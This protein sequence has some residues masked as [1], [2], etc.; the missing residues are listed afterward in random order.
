MENESDAQYSKLEANSNEVQSSSLSTSQNGRRVIEATEVTVI[1]EAR[2]VSEAYAG[3]GRATLQHRG[4]IAV[5]EILV[6]GEIPI[7]SSAYLKAV[8]EVPKPDTIQITRMDKETLSFTMKSCRGWDRLPT[9]FFVTFFVLFWNGCLLGTAI[10]G[11]G[12][13]ILLL[14]HTWVGFGIAYWWMQLVFNKI[15]FS[16]TRD[17]LVVDIIPFKSP[18]CYRDDT[19]CELDL[20][21]MNI[22]D[23][24]CKRNI[25][26]DQKG[27]QIVS[28]DVHFELYGGIRNTFIK[29]LPL[30][31]ALYLQQEIERFIEIGDEV[32]LVGDQGGIQLGG[33]VSIEAQD[34]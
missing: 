9:L 16:I 26:S 1:H 22:R 30:E 12:I 3:N 14:P 15:H 24:C 10:A 18:R 25:S 2:V 28:Y 34:T 29:H 27:N 31:E 5:M 8:Y 19:D 32:M 17:S 21:N 20:T 6:P 4:N 11:Y 23:A 7:T 13:A 33:V